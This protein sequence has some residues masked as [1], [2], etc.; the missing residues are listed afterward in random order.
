MYGQTLLN[1]KSL[2]TEDRRKAL[3]ILAEMK[4]RGIPIP[5]GLEVPDGKTTYSWNLDENNYF[6]KIECTSNR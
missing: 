5:A 4:S 2:S 1:K 3:M 6:I